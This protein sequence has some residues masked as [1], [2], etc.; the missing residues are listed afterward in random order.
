MVTGGR[1]QNGRSLQKCGN[2]VATRGRGHEV[3]RM[4][5]VGW[6]VT[7][8]GGNELCGVANS[9]LCRCR[10]GCWVRNLS[11]SVGRL[12]ILSEMCV[13]MF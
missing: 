5:R 3:W 8:A 13:N 10:W 2:C 7:G 4:P 9:S 11:A 6:A 12:V 1:L